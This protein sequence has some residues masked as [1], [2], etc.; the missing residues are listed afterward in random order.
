MS[1]FIGTQYEQKAEALL[2][3]NHYRTV[4]KNY[5]SAHGEIDIIAED[6]N[7]VLC[8]IEVR[9]RQTNTHVSALSSVTPTKQKKIIKTAKA[10]L[11]QHPAQRQQVMRFDVIAFDGEVPIWI[12]D[13]FRAR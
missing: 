5:F 7:A 2:K 8:F 12:K 9:F 11:S 10:Y 3:S 13:A 6:R 1:R 4:A